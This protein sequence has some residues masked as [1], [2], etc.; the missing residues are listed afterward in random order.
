MAKPAADIEPNVLTDRELEV[1]KYLA[2][3]LTN[4]DIAKELDISVKTVD[5]HRLHV[6][7]KLG[8]KNNALLVHYAVRYGWLEITV[9]QRPETGTIY[10]A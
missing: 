8:L 1:A 10:K 3:G 6:M 4:H 9:K 2:L 5:T 7:K